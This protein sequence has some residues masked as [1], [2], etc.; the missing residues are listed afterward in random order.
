MEDVRQSGL[1]HRPP[2]VADAV[3]GALAEGRNGKLFRVELIIQVNEDKSFPQ[4][5]RKGEQLAAGGMPLPRTTF[6]DDQVAITDHVEKFGQE[7]GVGAI[8]QGVPLEIDPESVTGKEV[9][10][11][12]G[13]A[14]QAGNA[15]ING[16]S[17][18]IGVGLE[19]TLQAAVLRAIGGHGD[20][21]AAPEGPKKAAMDEEAGARGPGDEMAVKAEFLDAIA[22][23][24]VKVGEEKGVDGIA[25]DG[26]ATRALRLIHHAAKRGRGIDENHPPARHEEKA[27]M[28]ARPRERVPRP[29][30]KDVEAA[31][32]EGAEVVH[33]EAI[34]FRGA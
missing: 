3:E 24:A 20:G 18:I 2:P 31:G 28:K 8:P 13:P 9:L 12:N 6:M 19:E 14:A 1:P 16:A 4:G 34:P 23:V 7:T 5:I 33:G 10:H 32:V 11:G 27:G 15:Q 17:I 26:K 25:V 29:Q 30:G 21:E 22:M